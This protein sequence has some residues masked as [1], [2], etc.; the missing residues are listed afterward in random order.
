MLSFRKIENLLAWRLTVSSVFL[1]VSLVAKDSIAGA[2]WSEDCEDF[3]SEAHSGSA[4]AQ[5]YLA[6]CLYRG[7]A[8]EVDH[9][10]AEYWLEQS[11]NGGYAEAENS[12]AA[13]WLSRSED[14]TK[15]QPALEYLES[16]WQS[17][18]S[19]AATNLGIAHLAGIGVKQETETGV[20][21]LRKAAETGNVLANLILYSSNQFG[22]FGMEPDPTEAKRHWDLL[23]R[24]LALQPRDYVESLLQ[25]LAS[26]DLLNKFVFTEKQLEAISADALNRLNSEP[27]K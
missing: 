5:F 22:Y 20:Q 16:A 4:E 2:G 11:A 27:G 25:N 7:L 18:V 17:G 9:V 13:I 24:Q 21:W 23:S 14:T 8:G 1:A 26:D 10:A 6:E 19:Q 3:E 12:I 15:Y